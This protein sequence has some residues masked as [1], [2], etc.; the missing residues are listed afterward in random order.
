[1]SPDSEPLPSLGCQVSGLGNV[2]WK[3]FIVY[4]YDNHLPFTGFPVARWGEDHSHPSG[5]LP[6]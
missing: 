6:C 2:R 5:A 3:D 1:M 4:Y